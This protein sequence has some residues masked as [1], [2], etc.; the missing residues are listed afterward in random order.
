MKSRSSGTTK[1]SGFRFSAYIFAVPDEY[2]LPQ[3]S[4]FHN[5]NLVIFSNLWYVPL[6]V[7]NLIQKKLIPHHQEGYEFV[8][9]KTPPAEVREKIHLKRRGLQYHKIEDIAITELVR[10]PDTVVVLGSGP[11][12]RMGWSKI[13]A[14]AYVIAVNEGVNICIDHL[15]ECKFIPAMWIVNDRHVLE[16]QYFVKANQTFQ[17]LRVFGDE[18]LRIVQSKFP[19]TQGQID[20][21]KEGSVFRIIR[22]PF[23][24]FDGGPW[25]HD[26]AL[27][28]PGG[29]VCSAAL[30][31]SYIKGPAKRVYL[32][33]IDMS[34]DLHYGDK[35]DEQPAHP[36]H[37]HGETWKSRPHLDAVIAHY[38][39]L[40]METYTLSETK[41][42]NVELVERVE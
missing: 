26:P 1:L 20:A 35:S 9:S 27:F 40:G 8:N 41:L 21:M 2:T 24:R 7:S 36:D 12:G 11:K 37:R 17:G 14:N 31:V 4:L 25:E 32:C 42:S 15:D 23:H 22:G 19:F 18:V 3:I 6:S 10:V 16:N 30:W 5:P 13:P 38:V 33:G 28:K 34:K 29:T 39:S